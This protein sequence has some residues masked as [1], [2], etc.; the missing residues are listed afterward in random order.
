MNEN[1]PRLFNPAEKAGVF[2][3]LRIITKGNRKN[4]VK[5]INLDLDQYKTVIQH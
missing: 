3:I 2:Y 1:S 5:W 4:K